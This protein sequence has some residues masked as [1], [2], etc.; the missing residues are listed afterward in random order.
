MAGIELQRL[1]R[2]AIA[3]P[4]ESPAASYDRLSAWAGDLT[5]LHELTGRLARTTELEQAL[6]EI[7]RA[8]AELLGARRG[9]AVLQPADGRGPDARVGYGIGAAELGTMETVPRASTSYG[10]ILDAPA[11]TRPADVCRPDLAAE[12]DLHPR[13]RDVAMRLGY[14][15]G[16]AVPLAATGTGAGAAA[17]AV[18][19]AGAPGTA[20]TGGD[21][22]PAG[23]AAAGRGHP[24]PGQPDQGGMAQPG[25]TGTGQ[26]TP[27]GAGHGGA[28]HPGAGH[29]GAG[30]PGAGHAG[31]GPQE[32]AAPGPAQP[33]D[34]V[35]PD[36]GPA[37]PRPPAPG[38]P[39]PGLPHPHPHPHAGQPLPGQPGGTPGPV[40]PE[41]PGPGPAGPPP[42]RTGAH[43]A[44][45][46]PVPAAPAA[47]LGAVEW[48]YDGPARPTDRQRR[49]AG[50][51]A[52]RAGDH[53]ARLLDLARARTAADGVRAALLPARLPRVPGARVA[54]RHRTGPLGGGDFYDVL[55]LPDGA[56]GLA[57]GSAGGGG[58]AAVAAMGQLRAGLRAYAVMEGEDPVAVLSDLELLMR[59]TEPGRRATA[60]FAY[61]PPGRRSIVVAGA[62]H[63]PPLV[64]GP[65]RTEY[66]ETTLSAPLGMLTCWE[67][68]SVT[69]DPAPGETVLLYTDGLL[70]RTG[71][72]TDQAMTRLHH[73]AATAPAPVRDDPEALTDHVLARLLPPGPHDG[74]DHPE[75]VVLLAV[76]LTG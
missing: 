31:Y 76:Q 16:Y 21:G 8:G 62:G 25:Q 35:H 53:L 48:L 30:H 13:H 74:A 59:L 14:G 65:W 52:R 43:P 11:A 6:H 5:A 2:P 49:I 56:L 1:L 70:H 19:A 45:V 22:G 54:V 51:Y 12:P 27:P 38:H 4:A 33:D 63:C 41:T 73:A 67:A 37:A 10:R 23:G 9:F 61:A 50:L 68:P 28:G 55:P 26:R 60:L 75:D 17:G 36:H 66:A 57:V 7:L 40:H 42:Y 18:T 44:P 20:G 29:G 32:P 24:G 71:R 34:A 72:P 39:A 69:I 58:P 47:L 46:P 64:T 3:H 15:A